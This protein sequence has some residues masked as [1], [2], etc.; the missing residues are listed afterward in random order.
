[1]GN[2]IVFAVDASGSM[3]AN[4]R[5]A[6]VKGAVLSLLSDAYQK[7]DRIG[8][9]VFRQEEAYTALPITRS[10]ELAQRLL[11]TLPTGGRT[12]LAAG[13]REARRLI[14]MQCSREKD[15][16]PVLVL[17]SDGRA[18]GVKGEKSFEN[19]MQ[20][21][22]LTA[23]D[24]IRTVVVDAEQGFLRLGLAQRLAEAMNADLLSLEELSADALVKNLSRVLR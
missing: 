20:E 2:T 24:G 22:A 23:A 16:L 5:M 18:T 14:H 3:G 12:P 11:E 4:H 21:A 7:R 9:V 15:C 1:M 13:I 6:A 8:M 10:V 19:A 17:I